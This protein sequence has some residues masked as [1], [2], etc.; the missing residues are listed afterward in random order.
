MH[1]CN[2]VLGV[3]ETG[4]RAWGCQPS[5]RF[6]DTLYFEEIR[7]RVIELD[8]CHPSLTSMGTYIHKHVHLPHTRRTGKIIS[9]TIYLRQKSSVECL[10]TLPSFHCV[11]FWKDFKIP[12]PHLYVHMAS[13]ALR[14]VREQLSEV[15][16]FLPTCGTQEWN[17][18]WA[19][20][21]APFIVL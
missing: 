9:I 6:S 20:L 4:D 16:S 17:S 13:L 8:K 21:P 15:H 11:L 3:A 12:L 10:V 1:P 2:P 7:E 14:V 19:L 18:G 5:S